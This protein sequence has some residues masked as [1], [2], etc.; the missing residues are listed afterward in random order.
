MLLTLSLLLIPV[1]LLAVLAFATHTARRHRRQMQHKTEASQL[2]RRAD[3]LFKIALATQVHIPNNNIAN[4]L[5]K[6]A[7]RV[8][9][10]A[11]LL[12]PEQS[13]TTASLRECR[14]L[15]TSTEQDELSPSI[16]KDP[17]LEF[18]ETE[19]IEAQLHLTEAARL[20]MGLEKRGLVPYDELPTLLTNLKQAQ[21]G[22]DLRL[23][24]RRAAGS[25]GMERT[26]EQIVELSDPDRDKTLL[27]RL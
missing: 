16:R 20:L 23:Q 2:Q 21:R 19:L 22:L 13:A 27:T 12:D 10:Q 26:V 7:I 9:E 6:E 14:A 24:L 4:I 11:N 8:L 5:L 18:P 1:A 3:H 25:V 17:V 15:L